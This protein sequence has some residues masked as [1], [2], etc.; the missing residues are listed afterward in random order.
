MK[1]DVLLTDLGSDELSVALAVMNTIQQNLPLTVVNVNRAR[2]WMAHLPVLLRRGIPG[3]EA[4]ELQQRYEQLGAALAIMPSKLFF[5]KN[6]AG[7]SG[8]RN[9][10]FSE[11][12]VALHER[13]FSDWAKDSRADEAYR[14]SYLPSLGTDMTIRLWQSNQQLY[15]NARRS[16]GSIG[17]VPGPPAQEV[18]WNPTPGEWEMLTEAM[19]SYKFWESES[20]DTV[21]EGYVVFHNTHWVMEGWREAR[22]HVLV[23][24]TPN[25]GA[26]L[27]VG[28]LLLTLVP[29]YFIL[30][31]IE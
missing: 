2:D 21:P 11:H 29:D 30:P 9:E 14:F 7:L 8:W 1:Y 31:M 22:Y 4:R 5:P 13:I 23:D 17:P 16:M 6:A 10:W 12:L 28:L 26:A 25:E 18:Y 20:W 24:Q 3:N 19:K 27:E 15:A